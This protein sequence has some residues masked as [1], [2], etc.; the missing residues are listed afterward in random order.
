MKK[1]Y[2]TLLLIL[3]IF[4]TGCSKESKEAIT[5]DSFNTLVKSNNFTYE[6]NLP[7][8]SKYSYILNA[9]VAKY[10]EDISIEFITYDTVE[11]AE[12]VQDSQ[13]KS[14]NTLKSTGAAE[15]KNKG[16]NYYKYI[17][18]SNNYYMISSRIDNTLVF[19]KTPLTNK[20][21]VEKI[22][23]SIGY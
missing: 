13:I 8:Y 22:I 23:N 21:N 5:T 15:T 4:I 12:K 2:L 18:I 19:C 9:S 11:N 16:K 10:N 17:L 3:S 6:D 7:S 1:I 14:F 20:D